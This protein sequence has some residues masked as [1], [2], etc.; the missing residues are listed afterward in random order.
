MSDLPRVDRIDDG[1]P[2]SAH[3]GGRGSCNRVRVSK[4]SF[5]VTTA[6]GSET[7]SGHLA[8][9][10]RIMGQETEQ[11]APE[12]SVRVYREVNPD[13]FCALYKDGWLAAYLGNEQAKDE[14]MA[15]ELLAI[16]RRCRRIVVDAWAKRNFL[17]QGKNRAV[18]IDVGFAKR[19]GSIASD[20]FWEDQ[21]TRDDLLDTLNDAKDY[22]VGY[23]YPE[24]T[25]TVK[26]LLH[27]EECVVAEFIHD[28]HICK[29][30]MLALRVAMEM[31][32]PVTVNMLNCLLLWERMNRLRGV[33]HLGEL[34]RSDELQSTTTSNVAG[35]LLKF[36]MGNTVARLDRAGQGG[37][38]AVLE[39]YVEGVKGNDQQL[40]VTD[41]LKQ[42][43]NV[44][45]SKL[46]QAARVIGMVLT[47][48]SLIV[49]CL[50]GVGAAIFCWQQKRT[51]YRCWFFDETR[52]TKKLRI[53]QTE[54]ARAVVG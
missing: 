26:T 9:K 14:I 1:Y 39:N 54:I 34:L 11:D 31:K 7:Y 12:R 35:I 32:L 23:F 44:D 50:I 15:G 4:K 45:R 37:R 25:A 53:A 28:E 48:L 33:R 22:S 41:P 19:R 38:Q 20:K 52:T 42:A 2:W 16:Y 5:D 8:F 6:D 49:L 40:E 47:N 24:T 43:L 10:Q 36:S 51:G 13:Q 30:I 3:G 21:E 17:M 27:L 18:C 29:N 46:S